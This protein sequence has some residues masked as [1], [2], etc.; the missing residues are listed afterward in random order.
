MSQFA[1]IQALPQLTR[2]SAEM[3][4]KYAEHPSAYLALN[5]GTEQF[6]APGIDGLI[7]YTLAG[8]KF[9]IQVG[10][11]YAPASDKLPLMEAFMAWNAQ[12]GRRVIAVQLQRDDALLFERLPFSVNQLGSSYSLTLPGY[13][14]KGA[15]FVK[16]RNKISRATREGVRIVE[17]GHELPYSAA[18]EQQVDTIDQQWLRSKGKHV[19]QLKVL[20]GDRGALH[21]PVRHRRVFAAL[22]DDAVVGYISYRRTFGQHAGWMHDL[23]RRIPDQTPGVLELCNSFALSRF[24][25]EGASH[26]HF[27]FTPFV[28]LSPEH[29]IPSVYSRATGWVLRMLGEYG[30]AVYPAK[31]QVEYKLKW[32]PS[33]IVPEFIAFQHGFSL[34]GLLSLLKVTQSI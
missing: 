32:C 8:R 34:S 1:S 15:R 25:D 4:E 18:F 31:T 28:G 16:L 22:R 10:G 26:L 24:R 7:A 27:G 33:S 2:S 29:E 11:V 3:L 12:A 20:V 19:R 14:L 13:S 6:T 17:L 21:H 5:E 30:Q 9:T 23:S